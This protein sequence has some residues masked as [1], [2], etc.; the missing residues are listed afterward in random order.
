MCGINGF[1][2]F[3]R[4][5][6]REYRHDLIHRMNE[7]IVHRGP[8]SEGIYDGDW[9]SFGM[10]RLSIVDLVSGDQPVYNEDRSVI[11]VFN[12]EVYNHKSLRKD[13]EKKGHKYYTTTDTETVIHMYEEYGTAS[14]AMLDGMFAFAL[15]DRARDEMFIVRDK[16]GEKPLYYHQTADSLTFASEL[17][18]I[19][20]TDGRDRSLD[21]E[22]LRLYLQYTYIP[23]PYTLFEGYKKLKAGCYLSVCSDGSVREKRYW[24]VKVIPEYASMAYSDAVNTLR[25]M[26]NRSVKR[27][28]ECDVPFGVFLSGGIDS[29]VVAALM[30]RNS[31]TPIDTFT[32]GFEEKEYDESANAR[33]MAEHLGTRHHEYILS[34]D[35]A[36]GILDKVVGHFDE[37]FADS[38]AIPEF[39]VADKASGSVK[40]V[41]TGDAGDEMFL[42]Y[43]KYAVDYYLEKY[44]RI[45][46]LGRRA[47]EVCLR[48]LPDQS[49]LSRKVNKV[50]NNAYVDGFTKR[51][52]LMKLGFKDGEMRRLLLPVNGDRSVVGA[53]GYDLVREYFENAPLD[54]ELS[55]TQ[56]TDIKVV[57]EGDML[58]KVDRMT[59]FH[60]L[61]SR[62]PMLS[63]D[64][65]DF[66]YSIPVRYKLDG[67]NKKKILKESFR[68]ILPHGFDKLPKSGFGVPLDRWFRNEMREQLTDLLSPERIHHQGLLDATYVEEILKDHM[69]GRRNRKGELWSL[70]VLESWMEQENC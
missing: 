59:M 64:I 15:L 23:A 32:I 9:F 16:I 26:L 17:R 45:P 46:S 10:R 44:R 1:V 70:F 25:Q 6:T 67:N 69:S 42:G 34:F 36:L 37:P 56:Y 48:L 53:D 66:A 63:S 39:L 2:D 18:S 40:V 31:E 14:F 30:V 35:E 8:D 3:K 28:M 54:D 24:D 27:R 5:C 7:M 50:V 21:R 57:L 49:R 11:I 19:A 47:F 43:E 20:G 62:T 51:S 38:S 58:T 61:E 60:S 41:L 13:L 12:G 4:K 33:W 52:S 55:R 68:D 65:I 22:A 29:G